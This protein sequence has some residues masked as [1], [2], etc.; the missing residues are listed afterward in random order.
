MKIE[1]IELIHIAIPL[2]KPFETSF[3][4]IDKR[5]ALIVAITSN[6]GHVGYGESSPLYVP[7][8]ENETLAS[9]LE[10]LKGI[11]PNLLN[12]P[13]E[14]DFDITSKYDFKNHPVSVIGIEAA[15]LDLIA[16]KEDIPLRKIF[17]GTRSSV[18]AGESVGIQDSMED[19]LLEVQNYIEKGYKRIKVKIAPGKDI[20]VIKNIRERFPDLA[21][22]VDA[23]AAYT[24]TDIDHLAKLQEFNLIFVEQPFAADDYESHASLRNRGIV[25]CLDETVRDIATCKRAL[26]L[27]ACDIVNI[28]PARIGS[29]KESLAIHD[30]CFDAG[31][32]LFGG[33]R[34]ETG[35]GKTINSNFYSLPGFTEASDITPP[36]D[37]F[38]DDIIDPE[39]VIEGSRYMLSDKIG[40]GISVNNRIIEKFSKEKL[41]FS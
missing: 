5:P 31:I 30:Y 23:N 22:G 34:L 2:K 8:S 19:A 39:F 13:I 11:L 29:F 41:S 38:E 16:Q 15:Y 28:K 24:N 6:E 40:L 17:G 10:V 21:M 25:V 20:E 14:R 27:G 36:L 26:E 33:G 7:I 32:K 1:K 9:S 4:L 3:G 18:E 37:Y 12:L 35:I